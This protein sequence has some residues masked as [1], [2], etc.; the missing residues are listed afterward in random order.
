MSAWRSFAIVVIAECHFSGP[1][2]SQEL[3]RRMGRRNGTWQMTIIAKLRQA[4]MLLTKG[5][6][7]AG[8]LGVTETN[9]YVGDRGTEG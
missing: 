5:C 9:Y 4:D 7:L 1:Y 2:A 3:G 6:R 8:V